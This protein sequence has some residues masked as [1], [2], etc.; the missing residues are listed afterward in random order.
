MVLKSF[1]GILLTMLSVR[2]LDFVYILIILGLSFIEGIGG[3]PSFFFENKRLFSLDFAI[4]TLKVID[5]S[6]EWLLRYDD[7]FFHSFYTL[8]IRFDDLTI[9]S[10]L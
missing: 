3:R 4:V 7:K 8:I 9:S 1:V 6:I 10:R 2:I 5:F